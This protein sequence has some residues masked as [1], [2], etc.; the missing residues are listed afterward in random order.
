MEK[1]MAKQ[2]EVSATVAEVRADGTTIVELENGS[3]IPVQTD[4]LYNKGD[5]VTVLYSATDSGGAPSDASV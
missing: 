4:V 1:S 3:M 5:T 2:I